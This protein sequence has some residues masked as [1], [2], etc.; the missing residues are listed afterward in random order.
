MTG[1]QAYVLLNGMRGKACRIEKIEAIQG[2]HRVTL[3]GTK[4]LL[5][6]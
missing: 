6:M 2:G 4:K 3:F 1:S 5:P